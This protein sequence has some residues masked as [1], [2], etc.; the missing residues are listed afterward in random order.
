M[1]SLFGKI[2]L[3]VLAPAIAPLTLL[4]TTA[5]VKAQSITP[6][7]NDANTQVNTNGN[8]ITI[9]GGTPSSDNANLFHSFQKFG[10]DSG[11]RAIF[12]LPNGNNIQNILGRVVGG[13][14]SI[15]NGLIQVTGGTANLFLMNP[16]GILFGPNASL[17]VSGDFT[18]TTANSI[19]LG[20]NRF[21]AIG[22]NDY[23]NLI[24]T[25]S[26]FSFSAAPNGS[27]V[28]FADLEVDNGQNLSLIGGTVLST[29]NLSA[30]GGNITVASVPGTNLLRISQPGHL[31]SIEVDASAATSTNPLT[32]SQLLDQLTS[33]QPNNVTNNA[34]QVQVDGTDVNDGDVFAN[35]IASASAGLL[36]ANA[37]NISGVLDADDITITADNLELGTSTKGTGDLIIKPLTESRNITLGNSDL[38]ALNLISTEI[39][40]IDN[41]F[42]TITIGHDNGSGTV[43][44]NNTI[45]FKDPTT[46]KSPTGNIDINSTITGTNNA[47][48]TLDASNINLSGATTINTSAGTGDITLTGAVSGNQNLTLNAGTNDITLNGAVNIN[49]LTTTA[50]TISIANNIR[51]ATSQQFNAPITLTGSNAKTFTS[52]ANNTNIVFNSNI[53]GQTTDLTLNA[54]GEI[55]LTGAVNVKSLTTNPN[56]D[57][58]N[59]GSNIT[60]QGN[61]TYNS[62]VTFTGNNITQILESQ[63]ADNGT[64][65]FNGNVNT[66]NNQVTFTADKLTLGTTITGTGTGTLTLQPFTASR[67]ITIGNTDATAFNITKS[68]IDDIANGYS[69]IT[70]GRSDGTGNITIDNNQ[71]I[72]FQDPTIIQSPSGTITVDQQITGTDN[73]SI[74]LNASTINLNDDITTNNQNINL[75]N[76]VVLGNDITLNTGTGAG[77]IVLGVLGS[78]ITGNQILDLKAGTGEITLNGAVDVNTLT[79][80]AAKINIANNITT[81]TNQLFNNPVNLTG[82]NAKIFNSNGNNIRFNSSLTGV[83]TDLTLNAVGKIINLNGA[84]DVKSLN[85]TAT[86]TNIATSI[87]TPGNQTYNS[88][89][90]LTGNNSSQE[91]KANTITFNGNVATGNNNATFTANNLTLGT[92]TT[93]TGTLTLQPLTASRDITL[94]TTDANSL[95]ITDTALATI[96]DSYTQVTIG[97]SDGTGTIAITNPLVFN[98]PTTIKSP[99][100]TIQLAGT[101]TGIDDASITLETSNINLFGATTIDTSTGTGDITLTGGVSGGQTLNLFAGTNDITLNGSVNIN[102]LNTSYQ[103]IYIGSNVITNQEQIYNGNV[104]L[105]GNNS[106]Q[107]LRA[108]TITFNGNVDTGN[109]NATFTTNDLILGAGKT[110]TGTGTLQIQPTA[111][112]GPITIGSDVTG[113]L[114]ITNDKIGSI[115]GDY[116]KIT[117]GRNNGTGTITINN[118]IVFKDPTTIQSPSGNIDINSTIT[119]IDDASITLNSQIINLNN[120]ITTNNQNISLGQNSAQNVVLGNNVTLN[121]GTGA[122]DIEFG[123]NITGD[124]TLNLTA[125]TGEITLN[126]EV[127]VNRLNTNAANINI[128]NNIT[129]TADQTY[130]SDVTLTG[131]PI[132]L[133][134]IN[135]NITFNNKVKGLNTDLTLNAGNQITFDNTVDVNSLT[136]TAVNTNIANNITTNGDQLFDSAI[137]LT[138]NP[139]NLT[140]TN[141]N[142]TAESTITGTTTDLTLK[143]GNEITL[144]GDINVNSLNTEAQKTEILGGITTKVSQIFN[145]DVNFTNDISKYFISTENDIIFNKKITGTNT[146]LTLE[147]GN[148]ISFNG[149]VNVNSLTATAVNTNIANNITTTGLQEFNSAVTLTGNPITL[150]STENNISFNSTIDG[151][152]S[153]LNLNAVLGNLNLGGEVNVNSLTTNAVNTNI[154]QDITTAGNQTYNNA[155]NLT[156]SSINLTSTNNNLT[157]NSTITG[158]G[159]DLT[160]NAKSNINLN[161]L[162]NV[163]SLTTTAANTNIAKDI[164]TAELQEFNSA[165]TLTGS[166]I[167][168]TSTNYN[169]TAKSTITGTNTDLTLDAAGD[170]NLDNAVNVN[171]LTTTAANTNI[172]KNITTTGSQ[173]FNSVVNLTG[174]PIIFASGDNNITFNNTLT[175]TTTNL[176]LDA[177]TADLTLGGGVNVN[178]LTTTA[179]NIF[180][181]DDI[182]TKES[183]LFTAPITLTGINPKTFD[184]NGNDIEFKSTINDQFGIGLTT[185][186]TLNAGVGNITLEG[187]VSVERLITTAA[188]INIGNNIITTESQLFTGDVTLTGNS[189]NLTSTNNNI[190][191]NNT[192]T[193]KNTDLTLQ[194]FNFDGEVNLNGAVDV[195]SLS[196]SSDYNNIADNVTTTGDQVYNSSTTELSKGSLQ[197]LQELKAENENAKI[198]FTGDVKAGSQDVKFTAD[199]LELGGTTT[200]TGNL[201]IQP[202]KADRNITLGNFDATELNL[203][204]EEIARLGG[205]AGEDN[206]ESITIGRIDGT[207]NIAIN[208]SIEFKD[209]TTIKSLTG[210]NISNTVTGIAEIKGIDN[211]SITLEAPNIN[212]LSETTIYTSSGTGYIALNGAVSGSQNLTLNAG[213]KDITLTDTVDVHSLTAI[214]TNIDIANNI[215]TTGSQYFDG[216]VTLTGDNPKT[217]NSNNNDIEFSKFSL[218][219]G[220]SN[221]ITGTTTDL[222]LNAGTANLTLGGAVDVQK[223]TTTAANINIGDNITTQES[224]EFKGAVTLS[225]NNAKTF[226]SNNNDINF[227]S[228]IKNAENS[229]TDLTLN[230]GAG[231]LTLGD[232]VDVNSLTATAK[233]TN[234]ATNVTTTTN[235]TYNGDVKLT[236][237]NSNQELKST[238]GTVAVNGN[239]TAGNNNLT[240]TGEDLAVTGKTEGT[241]SLT[242]Q[243]ATVDR[244][245][246]LGSDVAGTL[247]ISSLEITNFAD[248]FSSITIGRDDGNG[249]IAVNNPVEFKDPTTIKSGGETGSITAT[250]TIT[251]VNNANLNLLANQNVNVSNITTQNQPISITSTLGGITTNDIT[252]NVVNLGANQNISTAN[253]NAENIAL[254]STLGGITTSNLTSQL[255]NLTANNNITTAN[256]N[257]QNIE[258]VSTLGGITTNDITGGVVNL[259]ANE[260]LSTANINTVDNNVNLTS[261]AGVVTTKDITTQGGDITIQ[262]Q[263]S[264]KTGFLDS[265][266]TNGNGGNVTLDP[267]GDIEVTAIRTEALGDGIGGNVDITTESFFRATGTFINRYGRDASISTV[268]G[269]GS[270]SV[271]IRHGGNGLTAFV[272]GDTSNIGTAGAII[273][274]FN[275]SIRPKKLFEGNYTQG[276]IEIITDSPIRQTANPSDENP[277]VVQT[278]QVD[279]NYVDPNADINDLEDTFT[280]EVESSSG[281]KFIRKSRTQIQDE[282]KQIQAQTGVK[283]ALVYA[284][285][286][287]AGDTSNPD[288]DIL[289][290]YV[291]T[292]QGQMIRKSVSYAT[293]GRVT[294]VAD[295]FYLATTDVNS[296]NYLELGQQLYQWLIAPYE[297]E[298]Q[299]QGINNLSFMM[300]DVGYVPLAALYD[301]KQFLIEK[302]SIGIMPSASSTNVKYANLKETQVLAMGASKFAKDQEQ[303]DL[304]YVPIEIDNIANKIWRGKNFLNERFTLENLKNERQRNRYGIIHLATHANFTAG[305]NN[306][307]YIQFYNRRLRLDQ[308]QELIGEKDPKPSD[309]QKKEIDTKKLDQQKVDLLVLSACQSGVGSQAEQTESVDLGFAGL[310]VQANVESALASL[311]FV[312]DGGTL[313]L[314]MEFYRQLQTAPIK[315]EAL[316]QAQLAMVQGKI[317]VEGDQLNVTRGNVEI[318]LELAAGLKELD[319]SHPYYW[320]A[321]TIVGS[322]W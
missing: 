72:E 243:S 52:T 275:N 94:G 122:G 153:N 308:I 78:N 74:T 91:L 135:N 99:N 192:I 204:S 265:S 299:K 137:N 66:G 185:D 87:T 39:A 41:G 132:T 298:L 205:L 193:G 93:G 256:I 221:T 277:F 283:P 145:T 31:L 288:D 269:S 73:A 8:N 130:N 126:G 34:G 97:H 214:A 302:Y 98:N 25:P 282:L 239:V 82:S 75:A 189:I 79:T 274:D 112:D 198:T 220:S 147:A 12:D 218:F 195:K 229:T 109:N 172:A 318:P 85:T 186:L 9:T 271:T 102:Q 146:N 47:S 158:N 200:G 296:K 232:A 228:T 142:I 212:L 226:S 71:N 51:T 15:I 160:L 168:L 194:S 301:G 3:Y 268:G 310:A 320:A 319:L 177:G 300:E 287:A 251:G 295:K 181:G 227:T 7:A 208:N 291:I 143:A 167:T 182:T 322:Q 233:T 207:G 22:T 176:T 316:R 107:I 190:T 110:I 255:I 45:A 234:I 215:T 5:I 247:N 312:S 248:G 184:S 203:T 70:I 191:F 188:N 199:N 166:P 44:I 156:G 124:K 258:F 211:A 42:N 108:G 121:T 213:T 262:A 11:E 304:Q 254:N 231:I 61:Q 209:A 305:D 101:I 169:I 223:L 222:T 240:F 118:P 117:I 116:T 50:A 272:V 303:K 131:N 54:R 245:I 35:N 119:G 1:N 113:T 80:S 311:W 260:N 140:S 89:V 67:N 163:N 249:N 174:T 18:A 55:T 314:M 81:T 267:E 210:I 257:G 148:E 151:L 162:V 159:T 187:A 76:N 33:G 266:S 196:I 264:M 17:N 244:N 157:F 4:Q 136:T 294:E 242:I 219:N 309:K 230:A 236:G 321:F 106:N 127:N 28:N 104:T 280:G 123:G 120:G 261:K 292:P 289:Y 139:I 134:S 315:S 56:A 114:N 53:D 150:T 202:T 183:Q 19:L 164:T 286:V 235:Q 290:L 36:A 281:K 237:T 179:G 216:A 138:G 103:N 276:N 95:S 173:L 21:N 46:I 23:E 225:G 317:K 27:I 273:A 77:N 43:T 10:L 64:I 30:P 69:K 175:G 278:P 165:V 83:N 68:K 259:T 297:E 180:I 125:G 171:S 63:T 88:G 111:Q 279:A 128:A 238:S 26:A 60:T 270:G 197:E 224:Q 96:G 152:T 293:R 92:A 253:I 306:N 241:G 285:F 14:A 141:S 149:A 6:A 24:G 62:N 178:S 20:A 16:A 144:K 100:G 40:N 284:R 65:V 155:V 84:V 206:F 90:T 115:G 170:I 313:G 86:T 37:M 13:D 246:T 29:G 161:D 217:F 32:L 307:S 48:I 49:T 59:I 57:I 263:E 133:T 201:T 129:T 252:G 38:A 154:A 58:I 250:A 105:T 2:G